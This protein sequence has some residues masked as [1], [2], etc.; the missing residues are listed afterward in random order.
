MFE[1]VGLLTSLAIYNGLTLPFTFPRALYRKIAG[2]RCETI[3]DIEDGWPDLA[4]GLQT[5]LD[6]SDGDVEDV[7][8]RRYTF[9][10]DA[11]GTVYDTDM[12]VPKKREEND[13][14]NSIGDGRKPQHSRS[15]DDQGVI[16][17]ANPVP[18][19]TPHKPQPSSTGSQETDD[20]TDEETDE[21]PPSSAPSRRHSSSSNDS[22]H[23]MVTNANR[24]Q[25]V[26]DYI[27]HLTDISV[28]PQ[29][30]AFIVGFRRCLNR[31][32][33]HLFTEDSVK[34]LVEGHT[35]ID[36]HALEAITKYDPDN[37]NT[38][39]NDTTGYH[40]SHPTIRQFW[41]IVHGWGDSDD[42]DNQAKIKAL[43][44]FVTA[45][46]R[47]PVGG[48]SRVQFVIQRNGEGDERLPSS[49]TCFGRLLLPEFSGVEVMRQGL[50]R[51]VGEGKGFGLP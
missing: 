49:M 14:P 9:S 21:E 11:F 4:R 24:H 18:E 6:W 32:A 20:E 33:H 39:D 10:V 36:T 40:A 16:P 48:M 42:P 17:S 19:P 13:T 37:D 5:L 34:I 45:S 23:P 30:S 25:Y 43:L 3:R 12:D 15:V 41:S 8:M 51:A 26:R 7:F 35:V 46:D 50:E 38:D 44:E 28:Q 31:K 22:S 29:L 2:L 27:A 1:M 47:L